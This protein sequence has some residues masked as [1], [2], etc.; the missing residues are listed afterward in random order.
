MS[1]NSGTSTTFLTSCEC[2]HEVSFSHTGP[3]QSD[4]TAL[5]LINCP[6]CKR[7]FFGRFD[8]PDG[9]TARRVQEKTERIQRAILEVF[10]DQGPPM[11]VRQIFYQLSTRG[12]V[13]K[14]DTTIRAG[15]SNQPCTAV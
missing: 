7:R 10:D 1:S 2:G 15:R 9:K 6:A 13:P 12:I 5:A 3:L 11:S 14:D 8:R 4:Q